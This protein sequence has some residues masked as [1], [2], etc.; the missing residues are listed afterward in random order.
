MEDERGASGTEGTP[1]DRGVEVAIGV[2]VEFRLLIDILRGLAVK[3]RF[4][5]TV[6]GVPLV[7]ERGLGKVDEGGLTG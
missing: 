4:V 1:N 6:K 5:V 3:L 2:R 7:S